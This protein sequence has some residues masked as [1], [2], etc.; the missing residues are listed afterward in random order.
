MTQICSKR[1][2]L[3]VRVLLQAGVQ[4]SIRN[5]GKDRTHGGQTQVLPTLLLFVAASTAPHTHLVSQLVGVALIHRL[6][7][8]QEVLECGR[9][10]LCTRAVS[11]GDSENSDGCSAEKQQRRAAPWRGSPK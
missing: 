9:S 6:G 11:K 1:A 2:Y 3:G 10:H 7:R 5:L 4:D 8:K